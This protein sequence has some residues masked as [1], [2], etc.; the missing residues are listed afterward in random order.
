[1]C[2]SLVAASQSSLNNWNYKYGGCCLSGLMELARRP[3]ST[4]ALKKGWGKFSRE[5]WWAGRIAE[6]ASQAP[7]RSFSLANGIFNHD[8]VLVYCRVFDNVVRSFMITVL[9][10]TIWECQRLVFSPSQILVSHT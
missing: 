5:G 10:A 9:T 6:K 7:S 1:M 8:K 4:F 3:V 2:D